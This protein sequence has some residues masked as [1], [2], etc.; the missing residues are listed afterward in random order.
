M[1]DARQDD[2]VVSSIVSAVGCT[3]LSVDFRLAPEHPYPASLHDAYATLKWVHENSERLSINPSRIAVGGA[4]S[5][6]GLAAGLSIYARDQEELGPCF[7]LLVYPMLDN[8]NVSVGEE[9]RPP[10]ATWSGADNAFAWSAYL[11]QLG[12]DANVPIYAAPARAIDLT[13]LP[14]SA[15]FVGDLDLFLVE[16]VNYALRLVSHGVAV[17]L[18]VYAGAFHGFNVAAPRAA[19]SRRLIRDICEVLTAA[20]EG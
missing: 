11:G 14:R 18:R 19:V 5:G 4:S 2:S 10:L 13:G 7:Q 15:I 12:A 8:E 17:D 9:V 20:L 16:D 6:G 1:G 3:G